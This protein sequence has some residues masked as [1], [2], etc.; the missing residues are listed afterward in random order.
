MLVTMFLVIDGQVRDEVDDQ[1]SVE[2]DDEDSVDDISV[3]F[4]CTK[5]K[6]NQRK[7]HNAI[8]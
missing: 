4:C 8:Q 1:V 5:R 6:K 2:V 3:E 7:G